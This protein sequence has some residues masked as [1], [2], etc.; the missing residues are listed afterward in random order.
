MYYLLTVPSNRL[1]ALSPE[2][3]LKW[4]RDPVCSRVLEQFFVSSVV[5]VKS[6][7]KLLRG[8]TGHFGDLAKDKYASHLI[9]KCWRVSSLEL[10]ELIAGEL[11][12]QER[13]LSDNTYGRF[14]LRNCKIDLFKR[15]KEE[16]K[17]IELG[18]EKKK[19]FFKDLF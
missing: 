12:S 15:R 10:K 19:D 13:A 18:V 5:T 17:Q 1:F 14:A 9:D 4:A 11:A 6:K 2:S 16:W 8:L 7:R 3:L